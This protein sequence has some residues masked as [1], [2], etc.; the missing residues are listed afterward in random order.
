M[1]RRKMGIGVLVSVLVFGV[2][3]SANLPKK[4]MAE[5]SG[6][7]S[8]EEYDKKIKKIEAK[9]KET[10]SNINELQSE[11]KKLENDKGSLLSFIEKAD[12]KIMKIDQT[13]ESLEGQLEDARKDLDS[14]EEDVKA[15]EAKEK[16]QYNLMKDRICY[17][18]ENDDK[19]YVNVIL[20]AT[21]LGDFLN[22]S[23]YVSK[24]SAYDK[25]LFS[26]FSTVKDD[27][28][29]KRTIMEKKIMEITMMREEAKAEKNAVKKLKRTKKK[30]IKKLNGVI[31]VRDK[32]KKNFLNES[33]KQEEK[34][35]K[36]L[37][38]KRAKIAAE[39]AAK[40]AAAAAAAASSSGGGAGDATNYA[41]DQYASSTSDL[42]WPLRV[43]GRIS[44]N[45][46]KR[47]APTAGASTYHKGID[48]GV[49]AG[50]PIIAAGDGTVVTAAYSSTAGNYVMIYHGNSLY[51]VY[52]HASK[53]AVKQGDEVSQ[54]DVIAYVGSTGIST[55]AHLHFGVSLNGTYV[56]P[57]NYVSR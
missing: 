49:S 47:K 52:M 43:K 30:E 39:E 7:M 42:R 23:E 37:A 35:E 34:I 44:S 16:E 48:I 15:A 53:L 6:T 20:N 56:N 11:I 36:L 27:T 5:D 17:I 14:I 31:H 32:R 22:R 57:L 54:G 28:V 1:T 25:K 2:A 10:Q 18:Y 40:K 26:G 13:L 46:G 33:A 50:T 29:N 38:A 12:K 41:D 51:T 24:I 3:V 8:T 9:Q 21:S 4:T 45:F 19:N 55:G